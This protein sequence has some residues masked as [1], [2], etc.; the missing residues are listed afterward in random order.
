M[1]LILAHV[2]LLVLLLTSS[3]A[4]AHTC[5]VVNGTFHIEG[6]STPGLP[7]Y[8][9]MDGAAGTSPTDCANNYASNAVPITAGTTPTTCPAGNDY[10]SIPYWGNAY[11][12]G[13]I[14]TFTLTGTLIFDGLPYVLGGTEGV[15]DT[16]CRF[17]KTSDR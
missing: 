16:G 14:R 5:S 7:G 15:Q 2:G 13:E 3:L 9:D 4:Q 12:G 17:R 6:V 10:Y 8:N 11:G 1:K